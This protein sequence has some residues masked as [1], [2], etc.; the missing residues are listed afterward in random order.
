MKT[1][2][3]V[4]DAMT[5]KPITVPSST[6]VR[7]ASC[8]MRDHDVG[9]LLVMDGTTLMGIVLADDIVHRVTAEAKNAAD[10]LVADV[11]T[12][13]LV[14]IT[15]EADIYDA[16]VTMREHD[17]MHLPVCDK[18]G[19]M[20]GFLT[21]KDVLRIEPTLFELMGELAAINGK[22]MS[23]Q[24]EGYC[25]VCGNFSSDL[26]VQRGRRVCEHCL[27]DKEE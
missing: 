2:Y 6:T 11:M 21:V 19:K 10:T 14:S 15:P 26:T 4:A 24:G 18:K 27:S 20:L 22:R 9:S 1:G 12:K 8:V 5:T 13:E 16:M 17:I 7:D 3:S 25:D 23:D